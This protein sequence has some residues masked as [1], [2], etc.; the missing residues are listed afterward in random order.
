MDNIWIKGH[1]HSCNFSCNILRIL[2]IT[3]ELGPMQF[4]QPAIIK[5]HYAKYIESNKLSN[6]LVSTLSQLPNLK[7][8][9]HKCNI[10]HL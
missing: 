8:R 2:R 6:H 10:I 3:S 7:L 4:V 5:G 9:Y 1:G